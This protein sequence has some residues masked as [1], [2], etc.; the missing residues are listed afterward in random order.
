MR[1]NFLKH[2]AW[3]VLFITVIFISQTVYAKPTV[4]C[5]SPFNVVAGTGGQHL[6]TAVAGVGDITNFTTSPLPSGMSFGNIT[7]GLPADS[8]SAMVMVD[9]SVPEGSYTIDVNATDE[10]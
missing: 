6:V 9:S 3:I 5:N 1:E 2:A 7:P 4:T 10:D 8:V